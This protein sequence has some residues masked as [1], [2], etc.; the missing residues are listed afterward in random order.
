MV[1]VFETAPNRIR[2]QAH[3]MDVLG[4]GAVFRGT[5]VGLSRAFG[6]K[7]DALR[8]CLRDLVLSAEIAC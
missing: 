8:A 1:T 3:I 6:L 4:T 5:V 7:P 2:E